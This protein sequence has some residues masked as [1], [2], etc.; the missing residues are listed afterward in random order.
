MKKY[1]VFAATALLLL[2]VQAIAQQRAVLGQ[3]NISCRSWLEGRQTDSPSAA[4]RTG[5]VL[6]F[7]SAFNQYGLKSQ[8][9]DVSEGKSTEDLTAWIDNY[10]RQH[11][12]E[13]L[14]TASAAFVD[15]FQRRIQR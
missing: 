9:G 1:R 11:Q 3:G 13:D 2:S 8:E 4:S 7:M 15:D 5:W 12:D 10:C 6:G 14:H